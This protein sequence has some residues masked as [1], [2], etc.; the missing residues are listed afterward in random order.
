MNI[1]YI[2]HKIIFFF[3]L[4]FFCFFVFL[5]N[6]RNIIWFTLKELNTHETYSIIFTRDTTFY[7]FLLAFLHTKPLLERDLH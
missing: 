4:F 5:Q 1:A 7:D 2:F 6:V 3:F